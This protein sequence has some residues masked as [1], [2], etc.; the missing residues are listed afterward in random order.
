M[1]SNADIVRPM[2]RIASLFRNDDGTRLRGETE[3][4]ADAAPRRSWIPAHR[5]EDAATTDAAP[6]A[7]ATEV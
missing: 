2:E 5:R 3:H 6:V 7:V 1:V 4:D